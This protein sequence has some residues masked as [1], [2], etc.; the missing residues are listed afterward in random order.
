MRLKLDCRN[1]N[2]C[3]IL[4]DPHLLAKEL[5][6]RP[7]LKIPAFHMGSHEPNPT[8]DENDD[9]DDWDVEPN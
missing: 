3:D 4:D 8:S 6:A 2:H 5:I 1:E 7:R 9:D